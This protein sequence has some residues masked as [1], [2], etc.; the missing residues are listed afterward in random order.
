[1]NKTILLAIAVGVFSVFCCAFAIGRIYESEK[2]NAEIAELKAKLANE[3]TMRRNAEHYLE[4]A[5][6]EKRLPDY[7]RYFNNPPP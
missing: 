4:L 7:G 3:E 2:R 6:Q 5:E 1:M